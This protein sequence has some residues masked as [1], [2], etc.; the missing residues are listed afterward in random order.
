MIYQDSPYARCYLEVDTAAL[1][2]NLAVVRELLQPQ[3]SLIA[4]LKADAYGYGLSGIAPFLWQHGVRRFAIACLSEAFELKALLPE[5]WILCMGESLDGALDQAVKSGIRLTVGSYE[6]ALRVSSAAKQAA[7][8]AQVH[9]KVDTGLHRIGFSSDTAAEQI[10][11]CLTLDGIAAEGLYTHLALHN[12]LQDQAQHSAFEAVRS[13]L[14]LRGISFQIVH[15]L[16]S[17]GL[18]RYPDWQYQAVRIGAVLY[19]NTP[20]GFSHPEKILLPCRFCA[21]VTRVFDAASGELIGYD[22]DHLLTRNT[23]VAV[24]SVGYA[25][26]YPRVFSGKGSV[27]IRGRRAQVLGLICMDQ[28][29][30][31]ATD[32]PDAAVGDTATLLGGS[33]TLRE[34]A[35]CGGLNRNECTAIITKRV[36][37]IFT[38][39]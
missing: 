27:E 26:G 2:N 5:A 34:Y 7:L 14:A 21:R 8:P 31:D 13:Q 25:D 28:M 9:F 16:D 22:D 23:R 11:R 18:T 12:A 35:A 33:I 38:C 32:I 39:K 37:R 4:V 19:G 15:M 29:M 17:I 6:A 3:T 24:L 30:V 10:T 1:A 20:T 36:P